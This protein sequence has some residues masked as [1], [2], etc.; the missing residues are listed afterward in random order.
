MEFFSKSGKAKMSSKISNVDLLLARSN[1]PVITFLENPLLYSWL[2]LNSA[3][4]QF[5]RQVIGS[6][7]QS[8]FIIV[9]VEGPGV[10]SDTYLSFRCIN[11]I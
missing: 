2:V 4:G 7:G 5:P 1:Y 8:K 6:T 10:A 11:S 3:K 9:S